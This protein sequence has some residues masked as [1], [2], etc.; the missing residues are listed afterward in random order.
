MARVPVA[1]GLIV[2]DR[3]Q[4]EPGSGKITLVNCFDVVS[5]PVFPC[6]S[7]VFS[8]VAA[9]SDGEGHL[10]M[11]VV[12]ESL[13]DGHPIYVREHGLEIPD[14]LV[15]MRYR[16]EVTS[17]VFPALGEYA[18]YL[19]SNRE[20]IADTRFRIRLQENPS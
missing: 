17:C 3:V 7:R 1:R 19:Y 18:A 14:R 5:A 4:V 20:L 12:I 15:E 13:D 11:R 10:R 16:F 2:C 9:L 8:V 6:R